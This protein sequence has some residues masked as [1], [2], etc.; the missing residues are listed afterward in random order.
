[1]ENH[2]LVKRIR[3]LLIVFI[4]GLGLSGVT[5]FPIESELRL[6]QHVIQHAQL[7]E[8]FSGWIKLVSNAVQ[9]TNTKYPF[10][11]YGTDWLAF[12]HFVI[13]IAFLGPLK[14]PVKNIWVIEFGMIACLAVFPLALI[15]GPARGIPFFWQCI[16]CS[17]GIIGGSLLWICHRHI[18]KLESLMAS[19]ALQK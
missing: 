6:G 18:K 12:A 11:A 9:E 16:D 7:P 4:A 10:I 14:D 19:G 15:A 1:M 3:R 13:A 8:N 17:F 5:A 2:K